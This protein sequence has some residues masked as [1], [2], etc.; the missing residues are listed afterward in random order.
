MRPLKI[1]NSV[2]EIISESLIIMQSYYKFSEPI[3]FESRCLEENCQI[4]LI[5]F[6]RPTFELFISFE[7]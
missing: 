3:V 7:V 4:S 6:L 5:T 2:S 1:K